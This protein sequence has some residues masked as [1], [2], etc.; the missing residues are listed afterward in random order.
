MFNRILELALQYKN[1]GKKVGIIACKE[2]SEKYSGFFVK[3]I[4]EAEDLDSCARNLY[5]QLRTLDE[6][7]YDIIISENFEDKGMGRAI[8]D[9]L[10]RASR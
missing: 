3:V 2:N 1:K 10:R 6:L 8:M 4:G 5:A 9:R 7:K